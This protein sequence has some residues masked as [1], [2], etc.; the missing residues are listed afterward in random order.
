MK[1]ANYLEIAEH[2]FHIGNQVITR[3]LDKGHFDKNKEI[4]LIEECMY[5]MESLITMIL[6]EKRSNLSRYEIT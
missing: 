2:R 3:T 4:N 6:E 5:T 1:S